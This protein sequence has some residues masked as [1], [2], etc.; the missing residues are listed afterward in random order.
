MWLCWDWCAEACQ[1]R[2]LLQM[3]STAPVMLLLCARL[4]PLCNQSKSN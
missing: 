1:L 3:H 2:M 4:E